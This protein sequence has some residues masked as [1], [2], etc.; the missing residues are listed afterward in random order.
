M[1]RYPITQPMHNEIHR[2]YVGSTGNGEINSLADRLK[3]P[4]WKV[5]RYAVHQGWVAKQKKEPLWS[6][7]EIKILEKFAHLT[8]ERIQIH[9]KKSGYKRSLAGIILKRKR[10]RF[11]GNLRGQSAS[12]VALCLGEDVHFVT[13]QISLGRLKAKRRGTARTKKNGGDM[14]FITDRNI[15]EFILDNVN[16]VDLRKVDKY[17]FTDIVAGR[18]IA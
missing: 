8:P 12:A 18:A 10:M 1:N 15:R 4:R 17:W 5:S 6:E 3:L 7:K 16:L 9:L 13:R 14:W 11:L 2:A